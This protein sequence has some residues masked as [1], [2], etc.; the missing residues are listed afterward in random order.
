MRRRVWLGWALGLLWRA[1]SVAAWLSASAAWAV[2]PSDALLQRLQPQGAVNDFAGLLNPADHAAIDLRLRELRQKTSVQFALVTLNSLEGGQIDDFANKLFK[3]WGVG[4]K[5]KNNGVMLLVAIK[6]RKARIEVGYGLEPI[7]PDALAGR[8]LD[9]Q[10]FPA[11]K[12][13]QYA[14]G[15]R[16]AVDR[17]AQI[18]ERGEPAPAQAAQPSA[19]DPLF[20][21]LF[22]SIFVAPGFLAIGT[23]LGTRRVL[24]AVGTGFWG[25]LFGGAPL[26]LAW[27]QSRL[28]FF[29]LL[30]VATAMFLLGWYVSQRVGSTKLGKGSR[31]SGWTWGG[32]D[33]TRSG[34]GGGGW[35]SGGF[36]SGG[37]GGGFGGGSSGGGG[38]SG[39]W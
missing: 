30:L 9:E 33:W 6:D 23:G 11:F 2:I 1:A 13:Q 32:S 16:L 21:V 34:S 35:S 25:L 37:G 29:V 5:E 24:A 7:L 17:I 20:L 8:V 12:R 27:S 36:S 10:L 28:A 14:E 26:V 4:E 39:G 3:K 22:F 15:M 38:A 18:L 19:A 31:D